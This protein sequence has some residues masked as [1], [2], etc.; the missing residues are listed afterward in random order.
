[1]YRWMHVVSCVNLNVFK[2]LE[3]SNTNNVP[4]HD[5]IESLCKN[6]CLWCETA[7]PHRSLLPQLPSLLSSCE[8]HWPLF[9]FCKCVGKR[10]SST[11]N[12]HVRNQSVYKDTVVHGGRQRAQSSTMDHLPLLLRYCLMWICAKVNIK[13]SVSVYHFPNLATCKSSVPS[14]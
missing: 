10:R 9:L 2:Y 6:G 3:Y 11:E 8:H 7:S 14:M 13:N 12:A 4:S 5:R 1:M